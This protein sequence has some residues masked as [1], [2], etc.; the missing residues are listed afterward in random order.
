MQQWNDPAISLLGMYLKGCE[1]AYNK[2][3]YTPM[4]LQHYSQYLSYGNSQDAP[5]LRN[6]L[7]KCDI[8]ICNGVLFSLKEE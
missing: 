3:T 7:R 2:D 6:G 1:S 5:L 8:H 4:F